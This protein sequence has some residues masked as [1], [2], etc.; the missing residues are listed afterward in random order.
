MA[1][2]LGSHARKTSFGTIHKIEGTEK[3]EGRPALSPDG[4]CVVYSNG[5][6]LIKTML[7][8]GVSEKICDGEALYGIKFSRDGESV[9]WIR[10]EFDENRRR[11]VSLEKVD[12]RSNK[13]ETVVSRQRSIRGRKQ[14]NQPTPEAGIY[15]GHLMVDGTAIDPQGKGSYLWPD[16]S[17]DGTKIVYWCVGQGCFVSNIDGSAPVHIGGMRAAVWID[18]TTLAGMYD[19]DNGETITESRLA[20]CDL[21]SGEKEFFTPDDM[22]SLY[23]SAGEG[24]IVFTDAEGNLY[25]ID[26]K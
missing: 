24:R 23:P 12:V 3:C 19:R 4:A 10:P 25:Y 18:D 17:P 9:S 11:Y 16:V 7:A 26:I 8:T 1:L 14:T 20:V 13:T 2:A 6:S 15:R 21:D 5:T 22:I